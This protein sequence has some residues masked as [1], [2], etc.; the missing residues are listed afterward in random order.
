MRPTRVTLFLVSLVAVV[1]TVALTFATLALPGV[2]N[3]VL[4]GIFPDI[5]WEPESIAAL[6]RQARPIGYAC[7][8]VVFVLI[9][10]GVLTKRRRLA[11]VGAVTWF[12]PAF[13][14]F[15]AAMFFL[16]GIG[17]LRVLWLP[18]WD[19]SPTLLKLGDIAYLPFWIVMAPLT[20]IGVGPYWLAGNG[21]A[22]LV[23]GAG[24][25]LFC[26]GTVTWLYGKVA[27]KTVLDFWFYR[28]S[29]HP[30][31]LGFILWSYGVMLLTALAPVPF[32][33][34]QPEPSLPWVISTLLVVC[35]ALTEEIAMLTRADEGYAAY[36][37]RT[38]FLL[39]LPRWLARIVTAPNRWLLG[40]DFPDTGREVVYTFGVYL[41]LLILLSLPVLLAR[42]IGG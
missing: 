13:G 37:R 31:Y 2:L 34:Y 18:F 11:V 17:I 26:G 39:P 1:F 28:Y 36:R 10:G 42:G 27:E 12:L 21:V 3:S 24:L 38:P 32:G 41:I 19:T 9:V 8:G 5:Y 16:T 14:Y 6:M 20:L 40:K 33:G 23:I 35:V 7:L 30:Q 29:R 25:F 22:S 15:A 4:R